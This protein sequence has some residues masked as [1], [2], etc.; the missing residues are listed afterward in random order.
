MNTS[1]IIYDD[2]AEA[3]KASVYR[4]IYVDTRRAVFTGV[5]DLAI[6]SLFSQVRIAVFVNTRMPIINYLR[7]DEN[8]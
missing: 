7:K 6:R 1:E 2:V 8:F 4:K 3:V 5:T